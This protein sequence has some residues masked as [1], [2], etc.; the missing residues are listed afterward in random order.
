MERPSLTRNGCTAATTSKSGTRR[1][2]SKWCRSAGRWRLAE[3]GRYLPA[4]VAGG[5]LVK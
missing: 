4:P 1:S 5:M 3:A 2:V